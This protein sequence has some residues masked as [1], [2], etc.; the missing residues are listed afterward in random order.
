ML[1]IVAIALVLV[2]SA[3]AVDQRPPHP[4]DF[5]R[6]RIQLS[7]NQ[8]DNIRRGRAVV[9][10]LDTPDPSEVFVFGAVYIQAAPESYLQFARDVERLKKMK[11]YLDAGDFSQPPEIA[12]LEGFSLEPGDIKDLRKC[13]PGDCKLQLPEESMEAARKSIEWSAPDVAEQVNRRAK[14]KIVEALHAYQSGGNETLGIYRDKNDPL[15]V[16]EQFKSLLSRVEFLPQYLP[17]FNRYLLDYPAG[18]PPETEDFFYWE[19]LDF[20]LKPTV[21]VN[22]GVLYRERSSEQQVYALA[23]KQLYATHYF[24]TA[25]DLSFCVRPSGAPGQNGFYLIKVMGSR[26]AGLTGLKGWFIRRTVVGRTQESLERAL[27]S[28]RGQLER[29]A[30]SR[31]GDDAAW[32]APMRFVP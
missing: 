1:L 7:S 3:I 27:N 10:I 22:H 16:A 25:L 19:K 32:A 6:T 2:L 28:I 31:A 15:P 12:D 11:G 23:I 14:T 21:R 30:R 5:F 18:R 17:T 4:E 8:I 29:P 13:K 24:Q 20:G 26:Q 9:R